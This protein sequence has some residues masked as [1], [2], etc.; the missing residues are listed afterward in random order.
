M[1]I[2]PQLKTH[3]LASQNPLLIS[4]GGLKRIIFTPPTAFLDSDFKIDADHSVLLPPRS[5]ILF[6]K[7]PLEEVRDVLSRSHTFSRDLFWTLFSGHDL[8]PLKV[9]PE[10][11]RQ[12]AQSIEFQDVND[13]TMSLV[14]SFRN[15]MLPTFLNPKLSVIFSLSSCMALV[16]QRRYKSCVILGVFNKK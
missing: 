2:K 13:Q 8:L 4:L 14:G 12:L 15:E 16:T 11:L 1:K 10:A 3:W 7:P 6:L 5:E 9:Q